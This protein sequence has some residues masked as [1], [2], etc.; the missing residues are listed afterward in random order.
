V[1][2]TF[3]HDLFLKKGV[4][5]KH[6]G[7]HI[8]VY[9]LA[10]TGCTRNTVTVINEPPRLRVNSL[11]AIND[12]RRITIG[13][14]PVVFGTPVELIIYRGSSIDFPLSEVTRYAV[15][16]PEA[17]RFV[18]TSV[19]NGVF[20]YYR[21]IPVEELANGMRRYGVASNVAIGRPFDY[22]TV[23]TI[24]YSEHIQAIFN[25]SCAVHGCHVGTED[26]GDLKPSV[27]GKRLH[28]GQFSLKSWEDVFNGSNGRAVVVPYKSSK[29]DLFIHVNDDTTL[30]PALLDSL[31]QIDPL[32]HM[33]QGGYQ[34]PRAQVVTIKR[35]ID[36]GAPNDHGDVAFSSTPRPRMFVVNAL[37]D[38]VAVIDVATNLV[39]R[40]INV[41]TAYDSTFPFGSPHHVK[42]DERGTSFYVTLIGSREFWKFSTSTYELLGRVSIPP[43]SSSPADIVFSA[44]GDTAFISD[45]NSGFISGSG[46][47]TMVN[48]RT[49]QVIGTI[50]LTNPYAPFPPRLPHGLL[51]SPDRSRLFV[52]N[53]GSGNVSVVYLA[54]MSQSLITLDTTGSSTTSNTSPYL[55][56]MTPDGRYLFVTDF[57]AGAQNVYI[58]DFQMDSTK[59]SRVIPIGGRSVHVAVTPDGRYAYVCNFTRHSVE[60]IDIQ[61]NFSVTTI[62]IPPGYG[63]Q[64]HGVWF[65]PDGSSAYITTEN[66]QN[67]D[68]P[69]HPPSGGA[70]S[71]FVIVIDVATKRIVKKIEVGAWGQGIAF[72][73]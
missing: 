46:R 37:E 26:V 20:Y 70:G 28:G 5:M 38:L 9:L 32:V 30:G 53:A 49:M 2:F 71:S 7:L 66:L 41:G 58:I 67:P 59:P 21:I 72:S 22:S 18:D 33:P 31:G 45:F 3:A 11:F 19:Q 73:P 57:N 69:H 29:S 48:T 43:A 54:D 17:D 42:V 51:V 55:C 25:S 27:L 4:I 62:S 16:G 8:L 39:I 35:W 10:L 14:S 6:G 44:T 65:T 24:R 63:R 15:V 68:P 1:L 64:P 13:W 36:Q 40:Y 52:T 61:N 34:L 50:T 23:T 12:D 56:D 60:V 47:I